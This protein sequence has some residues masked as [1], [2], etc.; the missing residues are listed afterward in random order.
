[1]E[2]R[3]DGE[4]PVATAGIGKETT[5]G[6]IQNDKMPSAPESAEGNAILLMI[7]ADSWADP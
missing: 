7:I 3:G 6:K 2:R 4:R 1:M 5:K